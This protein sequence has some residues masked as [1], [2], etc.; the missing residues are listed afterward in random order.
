[1]IFTPTPLVGAFV[2]TTEPNVD[3]RGFFARSWCREEARA[4]GIEVEWVQSN[5]SFNH[6]RGTLRGMHYQA[7]DW[8][9]KLVRVTRGSIF[10]VI[11]DLRPTSSTYKHHFS[12]VLSAAER[13]MLFVPK[14]CAHGF[15]SREDDT[16]IFYE[17]SEF[18]RPEQAR[19]FRF[20]DPQFAVAWP[21][22]EKILSERDRNLPCY[23]P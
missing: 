12:V 5:I 19:G 10:D 11:V 3:A 17:M 16:E 18:H 14:G 15:L 22:G 2:I 23:A 4:H 8:E 7:P 20:D 6:R 21:R 13:N 9:A 1:M